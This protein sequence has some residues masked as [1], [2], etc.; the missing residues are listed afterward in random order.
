MGRS[1]NFSEAE[2]LLKMH[3]VRLRLYDGVY[4]SGGAYWGH[5]EPL[6]WAYGDGPTE[7]QEVF[8][9]ARNRDEAKIKVLSIFKRATFYR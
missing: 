9:R 4:D 2:S 6:Y 7:L 8:V 5:G 1:S 3:L